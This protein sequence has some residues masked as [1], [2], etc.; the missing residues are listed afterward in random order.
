M[1]REFL[2]SLRKTIDLLR[3]CEME[4]QI[5]DD[6]EPELAIGGIMCPACGGLNDDVGECSYCKALIVFK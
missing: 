3:E 2:A 4:A 1:N 5:L 6:D